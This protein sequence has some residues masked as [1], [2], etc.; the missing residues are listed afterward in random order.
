LKS[1]WKII[2]E[3]CTKICHDSSL[4]TDLIQEISLAWLEL[5]EDKKK[6]IQE[7]NIFS[8]WTARTV[9]NQWNSNTST[10]YTKYRK[11]TGRE[12]I[13][14]LVG[15][16][17]DSALDE[18]SEMI[19]S[20]VDTL[21]PSDQNIIRAYFYQDLTIMQIATKYDVDKNFVWNTI[22]RVLRS[23]KR[24]SKWQQQAPRPEIL[25][26]L[27]IDLVGKS[28]LKIEERQLV[29]DIHN[30]MHGD[31]FANVYDKQQCLL[32]L[33]KCVRTLKL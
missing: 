5:D 7:K 27:L 29:L 15:E 28:R 8:Y 23:F 22:H 1:E 13:G 20:W 17:Y 9:Q 26:D 21:F 32:I 6:L 2:E 30:Q 31:G 10:F 18:A 16:E 12:F 3:I 11:E 25:S 24:R 4:L 19:K 33:D 14:D